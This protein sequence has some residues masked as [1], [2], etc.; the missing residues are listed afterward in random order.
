MVPPPLANGGSNSTISDQVLLRQNSFREEF[1]ISDP[2]LYIVC[3][4][5]ML[6]TFHGFCGPFI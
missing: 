6:H 1:S 4:Y 2:N 5:L 3:L